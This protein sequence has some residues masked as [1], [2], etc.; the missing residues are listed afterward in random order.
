MFPLKGVLINYLK[1]MWRLENRCKNKNTFQ[2]VTP[3]QA[4]LRL[5]VRPLYVLLFDFKSNNEKTMFF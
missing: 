1:A 5:F 4:I 3:M 2:S